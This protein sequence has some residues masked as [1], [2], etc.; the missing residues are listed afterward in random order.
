MPAGPIE[1]DEPGDSHAPAGPWAWR[2]GA[3]YAA[4][5]A[6]LNLD[7]RVGPP[8]ED[9][10]HPL[11]SLVAKV[12]FYDRIAL[13]DRPDGQVVLHCSSEDCGPA[14][15]N[16]AYRA[17]ETVQ[18]AWAPGRGVEIHL[19]KAIPPG[20]GLGGGSSDAAAVLRALP[21]LWGLD[22]PPDALAEL[23]L[24]LG[25]DVPLFLGPPGLVMTSRGEAWR[26]VQLPPFLAVLFL[27]ALACATAGVYRQFDALDRSGDWQR[28]GP[29]EQMVAGPPSRW[30]GQLVNHLAPAAEA[31]C[32]PLAGVRRQL[33]EAIGLPVQL[34]G[35]GSA[36]FV[37]CDDADEAQQVTARVPDAFDGEARVVGACPW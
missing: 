31:L 3:L 23:A 28:P 7:L 18:A 33:A 2:E 29:V 30:R 5:P 24:S 21:Q 32:P 14:E 20:K 15:R 27:P 22:V 34:T 13:R 25:S 1:P 11:D 36:M 19:Q 17:A 8:R 37:L 16:L 26:P 35:S 4:A 10:F 6:K 9:G 12:A